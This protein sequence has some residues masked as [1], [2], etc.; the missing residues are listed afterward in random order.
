[1]KNL[2]WVLSPESLSTDFGFSNLLRVRSML[3]IRRQFE[4]CNPLQKEIVL[5]GSCCILKQLGKLHPCL[6]HTKLKKILVYENQNLLLLLLLFLLAWFGLRLYLTYWMSLEET[7]E[8]KQTYW[9]LSPSIER[10]LPEWESCLKET[11]KEI[12]SKLQV[13]AP[14]ERK[15]NN[16]KHR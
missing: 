7:S 8:D 12:L 2:Y 6:G 15:Q 10:N 1:M 13:L 14:R 11:F 5:L 9:N 4:H 3:L 16:E